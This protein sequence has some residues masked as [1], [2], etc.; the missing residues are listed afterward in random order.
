[1][2]SNRPSHR[3]S[4]LARVERIFLGDSHPYY[5]GIMLG[6]ALYVAY[7][8]TVSKNCHN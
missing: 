1:M 2:V 5:H 7:R 3:S 6:I 4:A 8:V